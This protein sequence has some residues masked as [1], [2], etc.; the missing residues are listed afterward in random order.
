MDRL[1]KLEMI[2]GEGE[3]YQVRIEWGK[4]LWLDDIWKGKGESIEEF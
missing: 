3:E 4:V 1:F 2:E